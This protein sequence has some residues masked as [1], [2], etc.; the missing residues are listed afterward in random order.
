MNYCFL[1]RKSSKTNNNRKIIG[2]NRIKTLNQNFF[3]VDLQ[4]KFRNKSVI[5]NKLSLSD[6]R[7]ES[8][9]Y[10][11]SPKVNVHES[12]SMPPTTLPE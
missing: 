4:K 12:V 2:L 7:G 11:E 3:F 1:D 10:P 6:R 5:G 9:Q 8:M